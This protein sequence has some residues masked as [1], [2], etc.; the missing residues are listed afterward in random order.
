MKYL[1][2][3]L[4][5]LGAL[6]S[7]MSQ[8]IMYQ[9]P[10]KNVSL[11]V[12]SN[13]THTYRLNIGTHAIAI[14][15][16]DTEM[17]FEDI[18]VI[19]PENEFSFM[20]G[21]RKLELTNFGGF[22]NMVIS[23]NYLHLVFESASEK[24]P[25]LYLFDLKID[26]ETFEPLH[27]LELI[28]TIE[29]KR[30]ANLNQTSGIH[31]TYV[32]Y[33]DS[34]IKGAYQVPNK[35]KDNFEF[36]FLKLKIADKITIEEDKNITLLSGITR[37]FFEVTEFYVDE[38]DNMICAG[39][40]TAQ[41]KYSEQK[42]M[43]FFKH[44]EHSSFEKLNTNLD[45]KDMVDYEMFIENNE[46]VIFGLCEEQKQPVSSKKKSKNKTV[47]EDDES[48]VQSFAMIFQKKNYKYPKINYYGNEKTTINGLDYYRSLR[49]ITTIGN[50][51]YLVFQYMGEE[52]SEIN[53]SVYY[54]FS[55]PNK[56]YVKDFEI[57]RLD[58]N[59]NNV[60]KNTIP[61]FA[62][63]DYS[64][65]GQFT[66]CN[67]VFKNRDEVVVL[68]NDAYENSKRSLENELEELDLT[69]YREKDKDEEIVTIDRNTQVV[70][71]KQEEEPQ[72]YTLTFV[73]I[74]RNT[75]EMEKLDYNQRK[76]YSLVFNG[77][78]KGYANSETIY[79]PYFYGGL[80]GICSIDKNEL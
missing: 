18:L 16:F 36:G 19:Y 57:H 31:L 65:Y 21:K 35:F 76:L 34:L 5:T 22:S 27:D 20:D 51:Y 42:T 24:K 54:G 72:A 58:S 59:L 33:R 41:D 73:S 9:K 45:K 49:N 50:E 17:A 38:N 30:Q 78:I 52:E 79:L 62:V 8:E 10:G 61:Y 3:T 39:E 40:K 70:H 23:G 4:L 25:K 64:E 1:I 46:P 12:G 66:R 26:L 32:S 74:D 48:N 53:S 43:F 7:G 55:P 60:W 11:I 68:Y 56:T 14:S 71:E 15:K 77:R 80:F 75:G 47:V 69:V 2:I 13:T 37:D 6:T 63:Y 44:H 28:Y 29:S 67:L